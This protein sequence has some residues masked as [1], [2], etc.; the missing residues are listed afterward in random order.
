MGM[1]S[2]QGTN[3]GSMS[4][5]YTQVLNTFL[6]TAASRFSLAGTR[7]FLYVL[8]HTA[9]YHQDAVSL[10]LEELMH[11]RRYP[12]GNR[13]DA[14]TQL[15]RPSVI[16]GLEEL[17]DYNVLACAMSGA[18]RGTEHAYSICPPEAWRDSIGKDSLP[19]PE[20]G[21]ESFGKES[22]P[23]TGDNG[24]ESLPISATIG[25]ETLP[26]PSRQPRRHAA[27]RAPK[28]TR[29]KETQ[30]KE[31]SDADAHASGASDA[32][33]A[34][35]DAPSPVNAKPQKREP[36]YSGEEQAYVRELVD[37]YKHRLRVKRLSA[38]GK[39][40]AAAHF[41]YR[42]GP[43]GEPVLVDVVLHVYD[44]MK[45]RPFWRG[46]L[47][48]LQKVAEQFPAYVADPA[49]FVADGGPLRAVASRAGVTQG[50]ADPPLP[51]DAGDA[52][53]GAE[54]PEPEPLRVF[55]LAG[56]TDGGKVWRAVAEALRKT[57]SATQFD[58]TFGGARLLLP[59]KH[60]TAPPATPP[61]PGAECAA[62]CLPTLVLH[63][64]FSLDMATTR[65]GT[66]IEQ[67]FQRAA[68]SI[69]R[70]RLA[71][72]AEVDMTP[73]PEPES[74]PTELAPVIALSP[75]RTRPRPTAPDDDDTNR[76][77]GA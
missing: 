45:A 70:L 41:F 56:Y 51:D 1:A 36:R 66:R 25:K 77:K 35:P 31:T 64:A 23:I 29:E 12:A 8:R 63:S 14:G 57:M 55:H 32:H 19:I 76:P 15:S 6:E 72:A 46:K 11:G 33:A 4:P 75:H 9:G 47:L 24:K 38:E 18:G 62:E 40:R 22:L 3:G 21:K 5:G 71:T 27:R 68:P 48:S 28:E 73:E 65:Y 44:L 53:A 60:A 74:I 58:A 26:F 20:I 67:A 13:Y 39:E 10:S 17:R 30:K 2:A 34:S 59:P 50:S 37:A 43:D 69:G 52:D 61:P 7:C 49:A 42:A 54:P 16:S